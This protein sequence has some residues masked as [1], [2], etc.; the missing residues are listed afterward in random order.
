M[1][2][3][4]ILYIGFGYYIRGKTTTDSKNDRYKTFYRTYWL[5]IYIRSSEFRGGKSAGKCILCVGFGYCIGDNK[6]AIDSKDIK[7]N[8]GIDNN[9]NSFKLNISLYRIY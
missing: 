7:V 4:G 9:L 2:S 5:K 6:I 1:A 3:R 8:K